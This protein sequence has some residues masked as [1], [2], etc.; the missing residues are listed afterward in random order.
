MTTL[1]TISEE[2]KHEDD[3]ISQLRSVL[4]KPLSTT[5]KVPS[6]VVCTEVC[7]FD[8]EGKLRY[9]HEGVLST[10]TYETHGLNCEFNSCK[11]CYWCPEGTKF[12]NAEVMMDNPEGKLEVFNSPPLT[13]NE[14]ASSPKRP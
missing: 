3:S 9:D 6:N 1:S 12:P 13:R 5:A 2:P 7:M 4:S 8:H 11:G 10:P 14:P